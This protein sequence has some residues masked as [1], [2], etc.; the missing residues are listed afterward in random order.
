MKNYK[1]SRE[2][3]PCENDLISLLDRL[4]HRRWDGAK[5]GHCDQAAGRRSNL[6]FEFCSVVLHFTL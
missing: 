6:N 4:V 5:E 2:S 1:L 3:L